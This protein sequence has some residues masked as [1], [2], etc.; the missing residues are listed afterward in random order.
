MSAFGQKD[1][2][3]WSPLFKCNADFRIGPPYRTAMMAYTIND[4]FKVRRNADS[5]R[6]LQSRANL[7]NVPSCTLELWRFFANHDECAFQYS[8][9]RSSAPSFTGRAIL[10]IRRTTRPSIFSPEAS[11]R[12]IL[13]SHYSLA[14]AERAPQDRH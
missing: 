4:D 9:T 7:R 12:R 6:N 13:N 3:R 10:P 1:L 14:F 8:M 5:C 11:C 2:P